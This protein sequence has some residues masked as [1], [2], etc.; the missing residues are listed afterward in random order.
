MK[1][2]KWWLVGLA[3]IPILLA[4]TYAGLLGF[5]ALIGFTPGTDLPGTVHIPPAWIRREKPTVLELE[6]STYMGSPLGARLS[7]VTCHYRL[8]G[9]PSY[10]PIPMASTVISD[11]S[12]KAR[13]ELPAFGADAKG[14]VEYYFSFLCNEVPLTRESAEAPCRVALR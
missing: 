2:L 13:V 10:T 4:A 6:L 5:I 11:K 3:A 12:V 8:A 9:T 14:P 1:P 7:G